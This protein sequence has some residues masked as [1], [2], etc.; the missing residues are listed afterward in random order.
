VIHPAELHVPDDV[1]D[2][3]EADASRRLAVLDD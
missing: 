3:L 2:V 1:V